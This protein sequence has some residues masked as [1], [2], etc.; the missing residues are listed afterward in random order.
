MKSV[1]FCYWLQGLFEVG[2][3]TTLDAEQV[4]TIKNHLN[5]VFVHEIDPSYPQGQQKAL[6]ET[7]EAGKPKIGGVSPD[8]MVMRC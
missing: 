8:G 3:P 2:K 1:E 5:M 6:N 7:H 4:T